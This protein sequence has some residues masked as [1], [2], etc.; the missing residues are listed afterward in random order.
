[1]AS[2]VRKLPHIVVERAELVFVDLNA[3]FLD[4][5]EPVFALLGEQKALLSKLLRCQD[6]D[7]VT[8]HPPP[9]PPIQGGGK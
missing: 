9:P 1:M 6:R 3:A 4:Q 5:Q 2:K 8:L 7:D